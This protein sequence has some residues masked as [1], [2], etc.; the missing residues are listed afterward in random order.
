[1]QVSKVENLFI[2]VPYYFVWLCSLS[3]FW[4]THISAIWS[5]STTCELGFPRARLWRNGKSWKTPMTTPWPRWSCQVPGRTTGGDGR[6][7][8]NIFDA[9]ELPGFV[10]KCGETGLFYIC[11]MDFDWE[12][13]WEDEHVVWNCAKP[14][15]FLSDDFTWILHVGVTREYQVCF[16]TLGQCLNS[17][18]CSGLII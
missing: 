10:L 9:Q 2:S 17:W 13:R 3:T 14:W 6:E 11:F 8:L 16:R 18:V 1:M 7:S 4:L 5:V 12:H 15:T